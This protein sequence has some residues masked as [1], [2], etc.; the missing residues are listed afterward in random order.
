MTVVFHTVNC[1]SSLFLNQIFAYASRKATISEQLA[2]KIK[3][4]GL[5][6][7]TKWSPQQFI[8]NHPVFHPSFFTCLGSVLESHRRL[9]GLLRM[10]AL[11]VLLNLLRAVSPC[12]DFIRFIKWSWNL[13][14]SQNLLAT[15][16]RPA[17][18]CCTC[19]RE[20]PCSFWTLPSK[21]WGGA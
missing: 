2:E 7:I 17:G 21:E 18:C 15:Y 16:W 10:E 13:P 4:S 12:K 5:G 9:D 8:L 11:I 14:F 6:L 19:H 3:L 20:S 1:D